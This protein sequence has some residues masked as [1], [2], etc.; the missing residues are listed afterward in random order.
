MSASLSVELVP[1]EAV[2]ERARECARQMR[3]SG[4]RPDLVVAI[5]RGGFVP[6][7]LICDLLDI[8]ALASTKV[9]HYEAGAR[10]AGPARVVYP[11]NAE[12]AGRRVL[13]ADDVNDSGDTL[14]AAR[15]H[16]EAQG[17]EGLGIAVLDEKSRSPVAADFTGRRVTE[18][19]WITYPWAAVE[20]VT[21]FLRD[22]DPKPASFE[23]ARKALERAHGIRPGDDL[24]G[25][26]FTHLGIEA[27]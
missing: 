18:W 16:L 1:W 21:A 26:V 24:L 14:E 15:A 23:A 19:H 7:R 22:V 11:V 10:E 3:G 27:G 9:T 5:A 13:L 4:F 25:E 6:A 2:V 8:G 20:D 17:A 12:V